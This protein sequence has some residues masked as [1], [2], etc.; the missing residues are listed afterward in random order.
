[1]TNYVTHPPNEDPD[2]GEIVVFSIS[3]GVGARTREG[4]VQVIIESADFM[5]QMP[6]ETARELAAN[7]LSA[8]EAAEV[9]AFLMAFMRE[10]VGASD[11]QAVQ[12]LI[13]FREWRER[14][15]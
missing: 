4:Y 15:A 3:S 11:E 10:R 5:T 8:A 9:D 13:E 6:P 12:I 1:M 7:L 2:D 14:K